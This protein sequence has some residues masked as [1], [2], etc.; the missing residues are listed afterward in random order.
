MKDRKVSWGPPRRMG[1]CI[2]IG[3]GIADCRVTRP[4]G[5]VH[6]CSAECAEGPHQ[7]SGSYGMT[8]RVWDAWTGVGP[9]VLKGHT[10]SVKLVAFSRDRVRN[11]SGSYGVW[12]AWTSAELNVL[13][14]H[15]N[16]VNSVAFSRDGMRIVSGSYHQCGCRMRRHLQS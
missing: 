4:G 15:T 16:S 10:N 7:L 5:C 9:N 2:K 3:C 8:V 1:H 6:R 11:V 12:D 14:R 13:K